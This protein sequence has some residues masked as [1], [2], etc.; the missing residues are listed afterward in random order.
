MILKEHRMNAKIIRR[1]VIDYSRG[2]NLNHFW[3][4]YR[5]Q[6]NPGSRLRHDICTF[7]LSRCAHRH[8]GYIGPDA[9]IKG[10]PSLPHGLHGI[11]ISRY[12]IIGENCWIYQNVTIGEINK[13]A[14]RIG[15]NCLIGAGAILVGDIKIGNDVKIGAGAV[16]NTDILDGCTVVAQ[17]VRIIERTKEN[18]KQIT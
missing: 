15:N 9:V 13:K 10:I 1:K 8:G 11:F 18:E 6:K 5:M 14:P 17:P 4:L 16:V 7:L 2:N 3:R 12:A